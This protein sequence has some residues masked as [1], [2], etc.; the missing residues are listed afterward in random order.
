[1]YYSPQICREVSYHTGKHVN[2]GGLARGFQEYDDKVRTN[3]SKCIRM[4]PLFRAIED[5]LHNMSIYRQLIPYWKHRDA[6]GPASVFLECR[7]A[8]HLSFHWIK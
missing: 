3:T 8:M 4:D 7:K 6:G 1:M 5:V 2:A